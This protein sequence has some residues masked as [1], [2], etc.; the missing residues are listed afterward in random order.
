MTKA[1]IIIAAIV[2]LSGCKT[3]PMNL[4]Q[5][6]PGM[7]AEKPKSILVVPAI[8][9]TT[10]ADANALYSTTIAPALAEAG[11]YVISVPLVNEMMALEGVIDGRQ[12]QQ[13]PYE[14]YKSVYGAD[15]VLFVSINKWD[16]DYMVISASVT[17]SLSYELI[18]TTTGNV[19][20]SSKQTVVQDTGSD[21]DNLLVNVLVTA[22]ATAAS[23]YVPIAREVN[24][25]AISTLPVGAYHQHHAN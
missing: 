22:V 6:F 18:S 7:Y 24:R 1:T 4:Q 25:R 20:W 11:Y 19:L 15:A 16:T 10:A 17:V 12:V 13:I 9:N 8:N 2:F 5:K 3:T 21:S 23:D 14:L